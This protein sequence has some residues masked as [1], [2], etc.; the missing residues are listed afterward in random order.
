MS[1]SNA[2]PKLEA[3]ADQNTAIKPGDG[4]SIAVDRAAAVAKEQRAL[5]SFEVLM[6]TG[7]WVFCSIGMMVFNKLAVD[8][9]PLSCILVGGQCFVTV[10]VM[11][12]FGWSS[13]HIGSWY[14]L[15]RWSAVAPFFAG[16]LLTSMFALRGAPLSLVIVFRGLAPIFSLT[17]EMFYPTPY[18]LTPATIRS[19]LFL[20]CGIALY[21]KDVDHSHF[22][23]IGWVILNNMFVVGDRLL[24]RL[25]LAKDQWPVDIS[26]TSCTLLNNLLGMIPILLAGVIAGEYSK[27]NSSMSAL[28]AEGISWI[29]LSCVVGCGIAYA[30]IW[31]QSLV[32]ATSFLVLA[33]SNKFVVI[34]IEVFIMHDG[35]LTLIQ[36]I[37]ATITIV[38]GVAYGK[39]REAPEAQHAPEAAVH[40]AS[41]LV[42]SKV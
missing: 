40:E 34:L 9:F 25:M 28:N 31:T 41:P 35:N 21:I 3:V 15:L 2:G 6:A 30:G 14:D 1:A 38:A 12:L 17:V 7:S 23:A 37:G 24:Q 10:L 13:L 18:K 16:V 11:L 5:D 32:N 8:A 22:G 20:L 39:A 27:L 19:L 42:P 26:K 33:T 36:F 29:S 4:N